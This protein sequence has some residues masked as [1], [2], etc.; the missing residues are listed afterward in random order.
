M[1]ANVF[2]KSVAELQYKQLRRWKTRIDAEAK[3][4]GVDPWLIAAIISRET[5]VSNRYCLP[6]QEG[7]KLGDAGFGH[8]PMQ[9][10]K[11]SFP[12]WCERWR[13][14]QLLTGDGIAMGCQVLKQ[15]MR[16][17]ARLIP[18]MPESERLRAAVAAYNCGE[19]N[20]RRH[21]R[22]KQDI[23]RSTAHGHYSKDVFERAEIFKSLWQ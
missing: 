3:A 10:D 23:D 6:P 9:I 17:I 21:Y 4:I 5:A 20:V 18:E 7:G 12:E 13:N 1:G 15:K 19:G 14:G 22:A 8:G 2:N 16:S 11:R